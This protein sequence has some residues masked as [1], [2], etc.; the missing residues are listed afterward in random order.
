MA[1]H[2]ANGLV[3]L[4]TSRL[5]KSY[6]Q[7]KDPDEKEDPIQSIDLDYLAELG[8]VGHLSQ[9][10]EISSEIVRNEMSIVN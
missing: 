4:E 5:H 2:V 8:L 6:K 1:V 10:E 7:Q 9:W 3:T